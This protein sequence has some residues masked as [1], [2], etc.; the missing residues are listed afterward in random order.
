L[1]YKLLCKGRIP[2]LQFFFDPG[3]GISG[4]VTGVLTE[5]GDRDGFDVQISSSRKTTHTSFRFVGLGTIISYAQRLTRALSYGTELFYFFIQ[6]QQGRDMC[7]HKHFVRYEPEAGKS[8][9]Y[10]SYEY[11]SNQKNDTVAVSNF[12]NV[13]KGLDI[14]TQLEMQFSRKEKK[15]D[16]ELKFGFNM[17]HQLGF[18]LKSL[19]TSKA[20]ILTQVES[21][22]DSNVT[23]TVF[24][25]V[26][27]AANDFDVGVTLQAAL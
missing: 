25:K 22:L 21:A 12:K 6:D 24:G 15:W 3:V 9:S 18:N 13:A 10:L 23:G 16:P 20:R 19:V 26:D 2:N 7:E 14:V 17:E 1:R 4:K 8:A 11:G 27:L 5:G